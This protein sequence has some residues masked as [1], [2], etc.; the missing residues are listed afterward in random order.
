M[1]NLDNLGVQTLGTQEML[2]IDGGI[3]VTSAMCITLAVLYVAGTCVGLAMGKN[4][5]TGT[6]MKIGE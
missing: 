2:G 5:H 1:K 6:D 4:P 3:V